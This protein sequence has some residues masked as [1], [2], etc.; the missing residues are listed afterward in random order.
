MKYTKPALD[1]PGQLTEL[2][3][4]GLLINNTKAAEH[5]S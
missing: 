4:D 3:N 5:C 2:V 1:I